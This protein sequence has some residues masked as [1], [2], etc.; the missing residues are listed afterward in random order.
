MQFCFPA[1]VRR[2][3][4]RD[5]PWLVATDCVPSNDSMNVQKELRLVAGLRGFH[6]TESNHYEAFLHS[7]RLLDAELAEA[8]RRTTFERWQG[9]S[10][11]AFLLSRVWSVPGDMH[12][13]LP[14][15]A[16]APGRLA[17]LVVWD[18][19]HPSFWPADDPLRAL[20]MGDTSLA[21]DGMMVAGRWVSERGNHHE[22]LMARPE[23]AEAVAEA[24]GRLRR[25]L[26]RV[27]LTG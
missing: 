27:G 15:G 13:R 9:M 11:P 20:A 18:L 19:E 7:G 22:G 2:W 12:P 6:T 16:I 5:L 3:V 26:N 17:N 23:A 8:H 1:A 14:A 4:S 21:I 10:D 25:H 24:E